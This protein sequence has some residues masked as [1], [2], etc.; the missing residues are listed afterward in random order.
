MAFGFLNTI[1]SAIGPVSQILN[2]VRGF[3][4]GG[5]GGS[6]L[7]QYSAEYGMNPLN[8]APT[9]A[10]TQAN[11]LYKALLDPNSPIL[12]QL[13]EQDRTTNLS[14]FQEQI[15]ALQLADQRQKSMG[16]SSAFFNPERADE[17]VNY[18]TSRAMPKLTDAGLTNAQARVLQAAQGMGGFKDVQYL[19]Q[20]ANF[21]TMAG[22]I[23]ARTR[24]GT[25][26]PGGY[27]NIQSGISGIQQLLK[28][29]N[30]GQPQQQ[31]ITRPAPYGPQLPIIWNR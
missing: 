12:K 17:T 26:T 2:A 13:A 28:A 10:E 20:N 4:G 22:D 16:R 14:N 30:I 3:K 23:E 9:E 7:P 18:L 6:S 8:R 5:G 31:S 19:R 11:A 27:G 15:K 1:S 25:Q 21:G 29:L 24:M